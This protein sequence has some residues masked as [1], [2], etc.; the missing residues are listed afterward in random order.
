MPELEQVPAEALGVQL[1]SRKSKGWPPNLSPEDIINGIDNHTYKW[2]H[3]KEDIPD[4]LIYKMTV[5][6]ELKLKNCWGVA[7]DEAFKTIKNGLVEENEVSSKQ[8]K[9]NNK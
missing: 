2:T 3:T 7:E 9:K 5:N 8:V 1:I 6:N 4:K